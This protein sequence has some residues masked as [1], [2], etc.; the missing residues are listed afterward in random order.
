MPEIIF[1][2]NHGLVVSDESADEVISKTEEV[3]YKIEEYLHLDMKQYHNSS[4]IYDITRLIPQLEDKVV[5]LSQNVD[6][7][8]GLQAFGAKLWDYQFCPD[9]LVYCGKSVLALPDD[10]SQTVF[11]N[12]L[13]QYGN[14]VILTYKNNVYILADTVKKAKDIESVLA[15]SAQI[16]ISN[17]NSSINR[18][19]DSE[20]NFLLNW[21]AE[22]Y[23]QSVK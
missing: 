17:K 9:C 5:Y 4:K 20:Q 3:L 6:V 18:L 10:F 21:D 7:L 14:P 13:S 15:F 16:A 19:S 12:H 23:R 11:T 1:L 22:K 8:K 2:Q